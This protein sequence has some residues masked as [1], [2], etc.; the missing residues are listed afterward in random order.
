MKSANHLPASLFKRFFFKQ[1]IKNS[2]VGSRIA[3]FIFLIFFFKAKT[4]KPV[5]GLLASLKFQFF[6]KIL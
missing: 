5:N 3:G 2:E 1:K 6:K 4:M